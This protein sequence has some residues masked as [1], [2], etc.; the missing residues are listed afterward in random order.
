MTNTVG[1]F[2]ANDQQIKNYF[3]GLGLSWGG[4]LSDTVNTFTGNTSFAIEVL[5]NAEGLSGGWVSIPNDVVNVWKNP[6]DAIYN[7]TRIL[8]AYA[9]ARIWQANGIFLQ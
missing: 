9:S 2:S 5:S 1:S 3:E 6:D 7:F 4:L 8:T